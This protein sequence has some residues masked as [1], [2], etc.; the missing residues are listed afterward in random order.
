MIH[1][2]LPAADADDREWQS[3]RKRH[4]LSAFFTFC[5]ATHTTC[6]WDQDRGIMVD[7]IIGETT[8]TFLSQS[9]QSSIRSQQQHQLYASLFT[10]VVPT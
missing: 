7:A 6:I 2:V 5:V 8:F 1:I 3:G 4:G 9:L 10:L